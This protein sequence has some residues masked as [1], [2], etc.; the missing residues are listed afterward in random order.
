MIRMIRRILRFC[1]RHSRKIRLAYIF[2][3][4]RALFMNASV[5]M[6]LFVVKQY[7]DGNLRTRH[8]AIAAIGIFLAFCLQGIF[9]N[10]SDRLQS[11]T[12][13]KVFAEKRI[14]FGEQLRRLPMGF[15]SSGNIGRIS[16]ILSNDMVFIE[17]QSMTIVADVI[18]DICNQLISTAFMFYIHPYLGIVT[19]AALLLAVLVGIPMNIQ[20]SKD[21]SERNTA[22]QELADA[23]IEYTEGLPLIKSYNMTGKSASDIRGAFARMKKQCFSFEKHMTPYETAQ[24]VIYG[25]GRVA[26]IACAIYLIENGMIEPLMFTGVAFFVFSLFSSVK[27]FFN[28]CIRLNLMNNSLDRIKAVFDEKTIPD[29][30]NDSPDYK[31]N[32]PEIEFVDVD[33]GYGNE[34]V[35]HD[36]SFAVE[37]G[38]MTALVGASGGGKSTVANLMAR[39]W[40][41]DSGKILFRGVDVK[42]IAM[43]ELMDKISM[44]FQRVYLFKDTIYNNISIGRPNAT[45]EEVEQAAKKACCYDFIMKLPYGFDTII[46]EGGS[47]LSGGEA[48]RIS[49]ARC[50]LKDS[51]IIILDEATASIDADNESYIRDAMNELCRGK[52]TIVIAHRL[53]TVR[54]ADQILVID[55]GTVAEHGTHEELL[56][57]NGIYSKLEAAANE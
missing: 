4:L 10:I 22:N 29:S 55:K 21:A 54:N 25:A 33:F 45:R 49:I 50:I 56:A 2:S 44:V 34:N 8:A 26:V 3:F 31:E 5:M 15:F 30:G 38:T 1:G 53:Y 11:G 28:Q 32:A 16:S 12:G 23:V 24:S 13:Y 51:P 43:S 52:T 39:F 20:A 41:T 17:E 35:L 36:V 47:T 37:R 57:I 40:D 14:E 19:L 9:Q 27:H 7:M 18:V 48:Q 6:A 42:D 46:G